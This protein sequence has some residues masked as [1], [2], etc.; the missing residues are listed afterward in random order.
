MDY[1]WNNQ[2]DIELMQW[3]TESPSDWQLGGKCSAYLFGNGNHGELANAGTLCAKPSV[4]TSFEVAHQIEC[5]VDC[6][7]V[8]HANGSNVSSCGNGT[9]G[10]LG[11]GNSEDYDSLMPIALLKGFTIVQ[12]S[13][14]KGGNGHTLALAASGEVFSW[15]DGEHGKLGHGSF[16]R[17]RKPRTIIGLGMSINR[18][19][20]S[21]VTA[22]SGST[23]ARDVSQM[24]SNIFSSAR[25]SSLDTDLSSPAIV[26]STVAPSTASSTPA[27]H[28]SAFDNGESQNTL[29]RNNGSLFPR[30]WTIR[31]TPARDSFTNNSSR[32]NMVNL[33]RS[34][35]VSAGANHSSVIMDDGTLWTFG[36]GDGGRLGLGSMQT[37]RTP[38]IVN[39][40]L[41]HKIGQVSCG[42]N[43]TLCVSFDG[44]TCWSFGNG[45]FGKL[46]LGHQNPKA[47]PQIIKALQGRHIQKICAG[48]IFSLFLTSQGQLLSCGQEKFSGLNDSNLAMNHRP[49]Q[50]PVLE[51]VVISQ[52]CTGGEYA[53]ALSETGAVYAWGSNSHAQLGLSPDIYGIHVPEPTIVTQISSDSMRI[54]QISAGALHSAAWT[55]PPST[56]AFQMKMPRQSVNGESLSTQSHSLSSN[57]ANVSY[58]TQLGL[59]S[60]IPQKYSRLSHLSLRELRKRLN[61][62]YHTSELVETSWRAFPVEEIIRGCRLYSYSNTSISRPLGQNEHFL[63]IRQ[64]NI[65]KMLAPKVYGL[66][67]VQ[68]LQRTMV[69]GRNY[70]PQVTV[71]RL[72]TSLSDSLQSHQVDHDYCRY[73]NAE[74]NNLNNKSVDDQ[75]QNI[76]SFMFTQIA[77]Q[78]SAMDPADLRLPARSWKVKLIGEGADDAGGVFDDTITEMCRELTDKNGS[79]LGLLISTPNGVHDIGQNRDKYLLNSDEV[80]DTKRRSFWFLGILLGVAI[81][82]KKPIALS[83]APLVWKMIAN[84]STNWK[85]V[86]DVDLH[87]ARTLRTIFEIGMDSNSES[88]VP[89]AMFQASI[90][91]DIF[92]GVSFT[93]NSIPLCHS[94]QSIPLTFANR[95]AFVAKALRQRLGEMS[96]AI[97]CVRQGLAA[98]VPLPIVQL[99]PINSLELMVCG[100]PYICLLAL[101]R[102]AR[103]RYVQI[104]KY[105][106]ITTVNII[107]KM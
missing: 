83:L 90:P 82:T 23:N 31:D 53:L 20:F 13:S 56:T 2:C 103:Y 38:Q 101:K 35:Y 26:L 86:E 17:V 79:S 14:S 98:M 84:C 19:I 6:T 74:K 60:S 80:T 107:M 27:T 48:S 55:I 64:D 72:R 76:N 105:Y 95:H 92:Q 45:D 21:T 78:V 16:D 104:K 81:R 75:S 29:D 91:I 5:G 67:M 8:I 40:L 58:S 37:K 44:L 33:P 97:K 11:I 30:R 77:L 66:P 1:E 65:R 85:D 70:G 7:F 59:P 54:Q 89:E 88:F 51:N 36:C 52:I 61:V 63:A 42:F 43:H 24:P 102:V 41:G 73:Q 10:R 87:Y 46:G 57:F 39:S 49:H 94:G 22:S 47:I 32:S 9:S 99:M 25:M 4:V 15:G 18:N 68:A 12:I 3:A 106:E 96:E 50:I 62:L 34:V 71:H 28:S 93:G 100:M 69:Q